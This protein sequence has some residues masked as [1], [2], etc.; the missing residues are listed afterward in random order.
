LQSSPDRWR[1]RTYDDVATLRVG[2]QL[3][4]SGAREEIVARAAVDALFTRLVAEPHALDRRGLVLRLEPLP[5]LALRVEP[6]ELARGEGARE[7]AADVAHHERARGL[8]GGD[9]VVVPGLRAFV[10]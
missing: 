1:S 8:A 9:L 3:A 10:P 7:L 6:R 5:G 4:Q 2:E